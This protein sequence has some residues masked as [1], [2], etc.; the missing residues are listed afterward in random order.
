MEIGTKVPLQWRL[1]WLPL[2]DLAL[3][4]QHPLPFFTSIPGGLYPSKSITV[5]GT[6]LPSA[7]R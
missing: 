1:L 7:Q 4:S 2:A 5:S 3:S 6:V